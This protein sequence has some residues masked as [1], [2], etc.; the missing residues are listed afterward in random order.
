MC[1]WLLGAVG[2]KNPLQ[3]IEEQ[4][5]T[6]AKKN[7]VATCANKE[8][9]GTKNEIIPARSCA[10]WTPEGQASTAGVLLRF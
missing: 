9:L 1:G 5:R 7:G 4:M 3:T 10:D 6:S 2:K 8:T